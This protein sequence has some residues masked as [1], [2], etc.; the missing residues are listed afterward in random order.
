MD[1]GDPN[2]ITQLLAAANGGDESARQ[3]LWSAIYDELRGLARK[4]TAGE[5]HG[6]TLQ[7][8]AL[9]H[10]AF[11]RLFGRN[12][13]DWSSRRHFFGAAARAMRQIRIDDARKRKRLK[14]G[15]DRVREG[16]GAV[17]GLFDHDPI[18]TL[19]VS[20]ALDKLESE[21]PRQAE[22]VMMRYFAGL[23]EE[24]TAGALGVS[25]RTV[26]NDWRLARAWLHRELSKGD[27]HWELDEK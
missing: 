3:R 7:P 4:M 14:R 15:G 24:E 18:E 17:Q 10:E 11:F 6:R 25:R 27:T 13:Q 9:V 22:V 12:G 5:A 19:A 8:T 20:E 2:P 26:Q 1:N 16:L 23:T 21:D